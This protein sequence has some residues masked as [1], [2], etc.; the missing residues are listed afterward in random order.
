MFVQIIELSNQLPKIYKSYIQNLNSDDVNS[1][2]TLNK[3]FIDDWDELIYQLDDVD[4]DDFK[5]TLNE[6]K[7]S[8]KSL[9]N[10]DYQS[11]LSNL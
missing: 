6:F 4:E 9:F 3:K 7:S 1:T 10:D 8:F 5:T 11:L 2:L